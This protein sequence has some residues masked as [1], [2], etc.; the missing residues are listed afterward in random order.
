MW[1]WGYKLSSREFQAAKMH[2]HC[3]FIYGY[4]SCKLFKMLWLVPL[5]ALCLSVKLKDYSAI[6]INLNNDIGLC[7]QE[8]SIPLLFVS[9]NR[10]ENGHATFKSLRTISR[11]ILEYEGIE[12]RE[13]EADYYWRKVTLLSLWLSYEIVHMK[14]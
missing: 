7:W 14:I 11:G 8:N 10:G 13:V 6:K 3:H 4:L 2:I 9:L 12:A 5:Q 1:S